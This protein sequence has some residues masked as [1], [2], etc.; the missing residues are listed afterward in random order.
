MNNVP[1]RPPQAIVIAPV[2]M[3]LIALAPLP[4]GYYQLLRLVVAV[5]GIWIAYFAWQHGKADWAIV[6]CATVLVFNP[7][8]PIHFD[9]Q[10]WS[11]LNVVAALIFGTAGWKL[12]KRGQGA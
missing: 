8:A 6:L 9:R 2:V 3:L 5:C 11:V 7:I 1:Q 4:Y 10:T 12:T